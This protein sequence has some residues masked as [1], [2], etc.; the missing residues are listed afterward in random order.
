M[1]VW[2]DVKGYE[3]LYEISNLGRIKSLNRT[4]TTTDKFGNKH[5]FVT[6]IKILKPS[7]SSRNY[8]NI[9]L[10]KKEIKKKFSV[11]RL[12]ALAF[13]DNPLNKPQVNHMNGVKH[14]NRVENLE[15]VTPKENTIHAHNN[16]FCR[17]GKTHHMS[18][19]VV[20]LNTNKI[21]YSIKEAIL[22]CKVHNLP[23]MLNGKRKNYTTLR[24]L[25]KS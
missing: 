9:S 12:V 18:K 5:S 25:N 21:F 16:N 19:Q 10:V 22:E 20:C 7:L 8:Q 13:L 24:F 11:H 14:D 15:W 4:K 1:E 23:A 2:K 17:K 6:K 3:G